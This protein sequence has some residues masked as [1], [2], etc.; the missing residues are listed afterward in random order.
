VKEWKN[1]QKTA[2]IQSAFSEVM[3]NKKYT[4]KIRTPNFKV[5]NTPKKISQRANPMFILKSKN[6]L[7]K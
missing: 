5:Q 3:E 7:A 1:T 6:Q 2:K 4:K